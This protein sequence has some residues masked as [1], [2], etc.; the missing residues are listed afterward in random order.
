MIDGIL[1]I[2]KLYKR[3]IF[4]VIA[5]ILIILF[6]GTLWQH[7]M[8]EYE[9]EVYNPPGQLRK[10]DNHNMHIYVEG[11]S[12][13]T[14]VF[15]VG[16]GTPCAYTDY[17]YIQKEISKTVRTISYD[18]PGFGWSEPTAIPRTIGNQ[19]NELHELLCKAG[20]KPPYILV[21]HSLSSLE[22]I[23]YAQKYPEELVGIILIDGGNPTFYANYSEFSA[24]ALNRFSEAIR[25]TGIARAL[26]NIGI[27]LPFTYENQRQKSLPHDI[28]QVDKIM[29]YNKLG[30]DKN[31][32]SLR[33]INENADEVIKNGKIG[34]IPLVVLTAGNGTKEWKESQ[35]QL[36]SWSNNSK[37]EEVIGSSHYIHWNYPNV[38]IKKIHELIEMSK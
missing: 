24:L 36:K 5:L 34:D 31:R 23:H 13:P 12:S 4:R 37:Q 28:Q 1:T 19:V 14:V 20:E 3:R 15:T 30:L 16:S 17:Y 33:T 25:V 6:I 35:I 29:F 18:R 11:E 7:A 8:S 38:I 10:V 2:Q 27:F 32:N 26:G 22:V 9:K 21:G